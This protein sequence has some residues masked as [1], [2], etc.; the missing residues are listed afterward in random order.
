[1]LA[2]LDVIGRVSRPVKN[3]AVL[4]VQQS[5]S[6]VKSLL[7]QALLRTDTRHS[8]PSLALDEDLAFSVFVGADLVTIIIVRAQVPLAVPAKLLDGLTHGIDMLLG[9]VGL[10]RQVACAAKLHILASA[11]HEQAGNHQRFSLTAL[12]LVARGLERL[13]GIA[14]ET[15]EIQTIVPVGTSD[16]RQP[17][18]TEVLHY[19]V[20]TDAQV[21]HQRHFA[22]GLIV[23]RH[24][25]VKDG[26]V[27]RFADICR[28]AEDEP[29]RIVVE[30]SAYIVV[31]TLGERLILMVT[32]AVRELRRGYIDNAL[33]RA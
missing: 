19:M 20:E 4:A 16:K 33:A 31:A 1:M 26:E 7:G 25:L 22:A 27:T 6:A 8:T 13:V 2:K 30:A 17:V 18:R 23:P 10:A 9:A 3:H 21:L 32:T 5:C 11:E 12:G 14:G 24:K 29:H 15:V 28:S